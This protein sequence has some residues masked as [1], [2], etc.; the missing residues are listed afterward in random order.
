M[1]LDPSWKTKWRNV[2]HRKPLPALRVLIK[3]L[4]FEAGLHHIALFVGHDALFVQAEVVLDD[5]AAL[6]NNVFFGFVLFSDAHVAHRNVSVFYFP[7][8]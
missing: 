1:H 3:H 8:Y 7:H 2:R 6:G 4:R 5:F